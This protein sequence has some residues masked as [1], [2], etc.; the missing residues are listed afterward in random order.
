MNILGQFGIFFSRIGVILGNPSQMILMMGCT[1]LGIIFGAM[2]GLT[3]TL[4]VALLTTITFGMDLDTAMVCLMSIYVG[5]TYG[6]SF[7]AITINIPGTA[8]S[9]ATALEGYPM[10]KKGLAGKALGLT[11]TASTIGTIVG[12]LFLVVFTPIIAELA[13]QFTSFEFFLMAFFGILISG[14]ISCPDTVQKGWLAGFFGLFLAMVGRDALQTYPRYTMGIQNL[15]SGIEVV[16]VLI[17][18]FGIP[19]IIQVLKDKETTPE[20]AELGKILPSF[21]EI[22]HYLG[23]IIRSAIIGV[24]IGAV[25]GIGEDIAAWV[26]YGTAKQTSKH[27]ELYG[28]GCEEGIVAS[29]TSNNAC[30]GGAMIPLLSLGI[31]GSPPTAMLLGA[32]MLHGVAPGPMLNIERPGFITEVGAILVI[33]AFAM[34]ICGILLAKPVIR[35]L[36]I[37]SAIFMPI[38]CILCLIGSYALG[39]KV[40][41]LYLMIPMGVIVYF[42]N[43][44]G[45]PVAPLVIGVILGS[46]ADSNLRRGLMVS[47]GSFSPF[48]T[49]PVSLILVIVIF[50]TF[51]SG[52]SFWQKVKKN[53]KT[54][55][56]TGL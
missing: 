23:T 27:P 48:V 41:N 17:G 26:A 22:V 49:R 7:S 51:L 15:E 11:T 9:A 46:M 4:G 1:F 54:K 3:S 55:K 56:R 8:A 12:M 13:L 33:A 35:L 52:T 36:Q 37:P 20:P 43:K 32:I 2:P 14:S 34:F 31:P 25:P 18:A 44:H 38:V 16:P 45:F 53:R 10:A 47:R 30:I 24:G 6:G 19:Q 42:L 39:L 29:E 5:G 50:L 21:K 40:F 28:T